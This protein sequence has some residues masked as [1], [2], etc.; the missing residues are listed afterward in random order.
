[1]IVRRNGELIIHGTELLKSLLL[2]IQLFLEDANLH[3]T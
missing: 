2:T 1:M 3:F